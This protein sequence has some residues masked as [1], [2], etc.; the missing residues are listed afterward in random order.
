[1][2]TLTGLAVPVAAAAPLESPE[3]PVRAPRVVDSALV[4][5]VPQGPLL[6]QLLQA[7]NPRSLSGKV[8][9]RKARERIH[10]FLA[11]HRGQCGP[12]LQLL[13]FWG[14]QLLTQRT[15]HSERRKAPALAPQSVY[16]YLEEIGGALVE[17]AERANPLRLNPQELEVLY[18]NAA[19]RRS[20]SPY[21]VFRLAQ[22]HGFLKSFYLH[23][24]PELD[25]S[26]MCQGQAGLAEPNA[27]LVSP[28]V[29]DLLLK[30]LGWGRAGLD[31]WQ[32]LRLQ[33]AILAYRCGLRPSELRSLRLIDIQ[34]DPENC[35]ILVRNNYFN[36]IK[37]N[38]GIRRIPMYLLLTSQEL[39][40]FS[41]YYQKRCGEQNLF[42]SGLLFAHPQHKSGLLP[43]GL[44]FDPLRTLLREI[45]RDDS[46]ILYHLRHSCLTLTAVNL[47]LRDE[48]GHEGL[49][50]LGREYFSAERRAALKAGLMENESHGRKT[51][52][53][54]ALL[55]GHTSPRTTHRHYLHLQ[56]WLLG[57]HLR[58]P[59]NRIRLDHKAICALTG[60]KRARG[61]AILSDQNPLRIAAE[62]KSKGY[63]KALRH[64][65]MT[66]AKPLGVFMPGKKH[67]NYPAWEVAL[68]KYL[69]KEAEKKEI[70]KTA[71]EWE[72]A[73]RIYATVAAMEGNSR[74]KA[75]KTLAYAAE[76]YSDRWGG[77]TYARHAGAR[78]MIE[79]L[80]LSGLTKDHIR[81]THHPR[82]G[83]DDRTAKAHGDKWMKGIG[84]PGKDYQRGEPTN[85]TGAMAR[86]SLTIKVIANNLQEAGNKKIRFN[87]GVIFTIEILK[88]IQNITQKSILSNFL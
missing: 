81:L 66:Q 84:M 10:A 44:L 86:G 70:P 29:Y 67:E 71:Q 28:Q 78:E 19:N 18:D 21:A 57:H 13:T 36:S 12:M 17:A 25:W 52:Y 4:A 34:G 38:A 64:P 40:F 48:H 50:A 41:D 42:G 88:S 46:L 73:A 2:R 83:Q 69:G 63:S 23:N 20:K 31:R 76:N 15:F 39:M 1:M 22:F 37:T 56:D 49:A 33:A 27:N 59:E 47:Q 14:L 35:E 85:K 45:T 54:L 60:L 87:S 7:L 80:S 68:E 5:E 43:D 74:K 6:R 77:I 8:T 82:R 61:F 55:A 3:K 58:S 79:L 9:R 16:R 11:G 75:M 65:L 53:L 26:A 32:R 72:M 62:A 24:L 51:Q 30:A